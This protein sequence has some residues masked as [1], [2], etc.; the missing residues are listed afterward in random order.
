MPRV[1]KPRSRFT[2]YEPDVLKEA[3]ASVKNGTLSIN[4][5]SEQYSI[6]RTTLQNRVKDIHK[7][8]G[9]PCAMNEDDEIR[10]KNMQLIVSHWGFP[11]SKLELR[12]VTKEYLDKCG[13]IIQRFK[14]NFPGK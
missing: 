2:Q 5:A 10:L 3:V 13:K 4:K 11:M 8:Q 12:H 14:N 1:Y 6:K 9:G 7:K